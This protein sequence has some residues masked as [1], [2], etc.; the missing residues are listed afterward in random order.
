MSLR[1]FER[2]KTLIRADAHGVLES[3]EERSLLLKQYVREAELELGRK[4]AR[5]EALA[6]ESKR[7]RDELELCSDEIKKL[8]ADVELALAGGEDELARF[9]IRRLI[10]RRAAARQL[11]AQIAQREEEHGELD[12]RLRLQEKQLEE[13]KTRA[14]GELAR[15]AAA[16]EAPPWLSE[17]TVADEE[18]EL[19]LMRR[20]AEATGGASR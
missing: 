11:E 17:P 13:L 8:D 4:R 14:R 12:E 20:R 18:V 7:L 10:P 6:E 3:L 9:A 2:V 16:D 15:R 19:E 5:S 1:V